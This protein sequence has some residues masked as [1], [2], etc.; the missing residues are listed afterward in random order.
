MQADC[1]ISGYEW[2]KGR[3]PACLLWKGLLGLGRNSEVVLS[4]RSAQCQS[5]MT[6]GW[7][8]R[9]LRGQMNDNASRR[10]QHSSTEL[11][12]PL[13]KHANLGPGASSTGSAQTQL[14]H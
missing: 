11:E 14:L 4:S 6:E 10:N 9:K 1:T 5:D 2:R 7:Q 3:D 13:A 8:K 12:Q